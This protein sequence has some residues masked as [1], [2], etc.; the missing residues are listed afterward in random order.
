[1]EFA[2]VGEMGVASPKTLPEA[3][4]RAKRHLAIKLSDLPLAFRFPYGHAQFHGQ[5]S[6]INEC[7]MLELTGD[8]GTLPYTMENSNGRS[9]LLQLVRKSKKFDNVSF[10][11]VDERVIRMQQL[12]V[13]NPPLNKEQVLAKTIE[14]LFR[15]RHY[16][17]FINMLRY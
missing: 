13:L 8:I 7:V 14:L 16:F 5:I 6:L 3:L 1:M 11:I 4:E 17:Q 9:Q 10:Q 12:A 2:T 15:D